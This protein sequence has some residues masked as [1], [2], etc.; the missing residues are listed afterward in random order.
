M[1]RQALSKHKDTT[2]KKINLRKAPLALAIAAFGFG[3]TSAGWA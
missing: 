1:R 3:A 2:M